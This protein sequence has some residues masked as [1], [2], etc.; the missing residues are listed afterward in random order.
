MSSLR[1]SDPFTEAAPASDETSA[2]HVRRAEG[3]HAWVVLFFAANLGALVLLVLHH[4][5]TAAWVFFL[6]AP[7]YAWQILNSSARGLGPVVT[8]FKTET[9]EVWLTIDD[10]PHPT[11]TPAILD[12][13]DTYKARATFFLIGENVQRYPG[14]VT[15]IVRRGHTFG[16]HTHTHPHNRFWCATA[17][18]TGNEIDA[19][20]SALRA[21]GAG[22]TCLFRSPVGLKNHSL[23]PELAKRGLD[24]VLWSARGFD[25]ISRNP[26]KTLARITANIQPG[27]ILLVHENP[28]CP[29]NQN[30][31]ISMLL[32]HLDRNRYSCVIPAPETLMR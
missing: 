30:Q 20:A 32:M 26:A 28:H 11:S 6:P 9:R 25:T 10:G 24:L 12:L 22:Q 2:R 16:N 17:R 13:L 1:T 3:Y 27:A 31:L 19:C 5:W 7:W 14:L 29:K 15:E 8:R 23:H 21:T 18:Q 4:Y